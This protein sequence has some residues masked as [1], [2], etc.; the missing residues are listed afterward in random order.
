MQSFT[1]R[2]SGGGTLSYSVSD[3]ASWL[4]VSPA[5]GSSAGEADLISV[6]FAASNLAP[7]TYTAAI[8]VQ[9]GAGVIPRTVPV[10]LTVS[11]QTPS[12]SVST[13]SLSVQANTGTNAASQS[14]TLR[15]LGAGSLSYITANSEDWI[16]LSARSG[17]LTSETDTIDVSFATSG[18][19]AGLHSGVITVVQTG[20]NY[21]EKYIAVNLFVGNDPPIISVTPETLQIEVEAGATPAMAGFLVRNAGGGTL[22]YSIDSSASWLRPTTTSGTSSGE[23]DAIGLDFATASLAPGA[24]AGVVTV[25]G[26]PGVTSRAVGV[27][28][29]VRARPPSITLSS[30]SLTV[31]A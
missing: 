27:S 26:G 2:N 6:S 13:T 29:T 21:T 20:A 1:V 23:S 19:P 25:R 11:S 17:T 24:Y 7:G 9:G 28:L 22:D 8:T 12:L 14:F 5:S 31:V 18:L 3:D 10:N 16:V 4:S 15:N 30:S